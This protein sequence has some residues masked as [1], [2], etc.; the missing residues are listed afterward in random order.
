MIYLSWII[1]KYTTVTV[2]LKFSPIIL[3]EM[4]CYLK[5]Q[6]ALSWWVCLGCLF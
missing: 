5:K 6:D 1:Q 3:Q 2:I 4:L